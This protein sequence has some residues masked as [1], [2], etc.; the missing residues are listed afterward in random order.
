MVDLSKYEWKAFSLESPNP[1][2]ERNIIVINPDANYIE[3]CDI[4]I[5]NEGVKVS[6]YN[7]TYNELQIL[8]VNN[9][10]LKNLRW[11]Y[12]KVK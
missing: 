10:R 3:I 9:I 6:K 7:N 2:I 1:N 11:D 5:D 8:E 12:I 4:F